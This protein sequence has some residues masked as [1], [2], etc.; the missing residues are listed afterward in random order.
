MAVAK[1]VPD[2]PGRTGKAGGQ[3]PARKKMSNKKLYGGI[4]GGILLLLIWVG[5]LPLTGT[6]RYGIC[7]VFVERT[8]T[9]PPE[10]KVSAVTERG[11]LVRMDYSYTN[12]Y[13]E[14]MVGAAQCLF[15]NPENPHA[16]SEATINRRAVPAQELAVF[17]TIIPF[18]LENPPSLTLP[19]P[20][21][22]QL[23][24][25]QR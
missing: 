4:G 19:P 2:R 22:Q 18:I 23:R 25:L 13:G 17:N 3:K 9:Y 6:M 12:E 16:L 11:E 20:V 15:R 5:S 8:L 21:P 7:Q 14:Y 24:D 10:M 1:S